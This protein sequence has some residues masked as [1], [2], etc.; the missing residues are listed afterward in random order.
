MPTAGAILMTTSIMGP[1]RASAVPSPHQRE[2]FWISEQLGA[3][4]PCG[5]RV[6][7][8]TN[9]RQL[10]GLR[11]DLLALGATLLGGERGERS[12]RQLATTHGQV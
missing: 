6:E 7:L 1:R 8:P 4:R 9:L 10:L 2:F 12:G 5:R 3:L 11:V